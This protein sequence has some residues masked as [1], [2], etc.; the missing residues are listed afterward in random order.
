MTFEQRLSDALHDAAVELAFDEHRVH[1]RAE[2]VDPDIADDLC[3]AGLRVD[4]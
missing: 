2:V 3:D 4:Q 1:D